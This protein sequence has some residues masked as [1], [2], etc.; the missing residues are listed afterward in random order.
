ME[1]R[2]GWDELI[3]IFNDDDEKL[4]ARGFGIRNNFK[5]QYKAM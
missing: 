4:I 3:R 1:E 2:R 5:K